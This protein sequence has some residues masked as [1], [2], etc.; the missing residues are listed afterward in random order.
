VG[1]S[2]F[3]RQLL[4]ELES[5]NVPSRNVLLVDKESLDFDHVR[6]YADLNHLVSSWFK[7]VRDKKYLFVDEIQGILEWEKA[8]ASFMN[9]G[10]IDI[11]ITGSNAHL[12]SS[13]IATLIS[14]RYIEFPIYSLGFLEFDLF[15]GTAGP[16]KD[17]R[18]KEYLRYGGMPAIHHFDLNDEIVY[19]YISSIF[20]T[21]L[22]KD[23]VKRHNVR[24]VHLLEN[25]TRYLFDNIGNIFS[26]KSVSDT[27]K[28]QRMKVSVDT[29]QNYI[30][31]IRSALLVHKV[32][33]Y[34]IRG[35]RILE[36]YDK[37][38]L[39]D[40]GIRHALL[41]Y[42]EADVSGLLENIVFLELLRRGYRVNIGKLG[43]KEID[44]IATKEKTKI[45]MQVTYLL[46]SRET[47]EREFNALLQ[48][49][50]NYPKYVLS[51]DTAFGSDFEGIER[52]NLVDFLSGEK[53]IVG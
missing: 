47:V 49:P 21:I 5:R 43:E 48:I 51:M 27:M 32:S 37:Y 36:I 20:D 39:A 31:Y 34:D 11:Y 12:F 33:R 16:S 24:N 44:F 40:I 19:Q 15:R 17:D 23:I 10:D 30:N 18:F 9:R 2:C 41:G 46:E 35:K 29:V 53:E 1:K 14:G 50:D 52:L 13:E 3:L 7:D 8:I 4:A 6:N 26:A 25:I 45:Y 28:S 42:R 38:Y 22:L